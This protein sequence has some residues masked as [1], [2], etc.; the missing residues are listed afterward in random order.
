M[1]SLTPEQAERCGAEPAPHPVLA[2][3]DRAGA[4]WAGAFAEQGFEDM[5]AVVT[6]ALS[7]DRDG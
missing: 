4:G 5:A 2:A 1:T 6:L 3:L 7:G